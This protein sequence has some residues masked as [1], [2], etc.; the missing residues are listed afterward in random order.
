MTMQA[1]TLYER[2]VLRRSADLSLRLP[3]SPVAAQR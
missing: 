2:V 1:I 3:G